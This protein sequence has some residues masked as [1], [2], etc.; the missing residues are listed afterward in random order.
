ME[1]EGILQEPKVW[2]A[3]WDSKQVILSSL[4]LLLV[5][6]A[7]TFVERRKSFGNPCPSI[8]LGRLNSKEATL[9]YPD[10]NNTVFSSP[11]HLCYT[12]ISSYTLPSGQGLTIF[13][14]AV[15]VN[16]LFLSNRISQSPTLS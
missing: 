1:L 7:R 5:L 15:L 12:Y 3:I 8:P 6:D 2:S 9:P 10:V 11:P 13:G 4:V 14:V 16:H